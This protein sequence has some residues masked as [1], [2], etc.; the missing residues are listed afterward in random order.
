M[1]RRFPT[2]PAAAAA[3]LLVLAACATNT[4][5]EPL[6]PADAATPPAESQVTIPGPMS[7]FERALDTAERLEAAGNEQTAIDRLTQLLG[8]PE[9]TERQQAD[10]LYRRAQLRY[11]EGNDV[12]GAISD[13]DEMLA[14]DPDHPQAVEASEMRDIARGEATS[15]NFLL[16]TGDLSRTERFETLF[17]LGEHQ[18]ALDLMLASDLTPPNPYLID[19]YQM[20]YLCEGAELTGPVYAATEPDGTPRSLQYCE[21]GK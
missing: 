17:R 7:E 14:L 9:L 6:A 8:D 13:L 11:G 4:S 19:L 18:K 3:S 2:L 15:L 20:G 21:F 10:V 16:E 12:F 5:D 1:S